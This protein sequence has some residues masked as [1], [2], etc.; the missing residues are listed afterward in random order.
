M[1]LKWVNS[2]KD[3]PQ[4]IVTQLANNNARNR[5]IT[6]YYI[7]NKDVYGKTIIF[8]DRYDQCDIISKKLNKSGVSADVMYSHQSNERNA[9]VLKKFRNN[10]LEVLVNIKMLTE[11][12][13]V[14]DVDTVFI[15]RQTTS[16]ISMTQMVGR[17]LRGPKFGGKPDA[18]LV[19]FQDDW[20]KAINWVVWDPETWV[21]TTE[22]AYRNWQNNG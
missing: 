3:L 22:V 7:D 14:P 8:A 1:Y 2:N 17:A 21:P 5:K 18:Y 11:G 12:T 16:I 19:F 15:T 10:E 4:H 9:E 20:Q 6:D 13:D